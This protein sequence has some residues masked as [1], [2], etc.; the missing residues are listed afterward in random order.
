MKK[1]RWILL[2]FIADVAFGY[3]GKIKKFPIINDREEDRWPF[4]LK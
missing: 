4:G 1:E 3:S 2:V